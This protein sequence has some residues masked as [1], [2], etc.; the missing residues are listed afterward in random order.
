MTEFEGKVIDDFQKCT[1]IKVFK[2][3]FS[4][5]ISSHSTCT[6]RRG[7]RTAGE[8]RKWRNMVGYAG[9]WETRFLCTYDLV[10]GLEVGKVQMRKK[11]EGCA[12]VQVNCLMI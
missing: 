12:S 7:I 10:G 4:H 6:L 8:A 11:V 5:R 2:C 3:F 1:N 9:G